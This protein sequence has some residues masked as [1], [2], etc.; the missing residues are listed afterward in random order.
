M[1]PK[2]AT[3]IETTNRIVQ[4]ES[5]VTQQY[6]ELRDGL[7][8]MELKQTG[9]VNQLTV[10]M[11]AINES[12]QRLST[13]IE[14]LGKEV[15]QL[16]KLVPPDPQLLINTPGRLN[17]TA[18]SLL[19][20]NPVTPVAGQSS[21]FLQGNGGQHRLP[22]VEFP[23]FNGEQVRSWLQKAKRFFLLH[24]MDEQQKVLF[25]SLNFTDAAETWF[26]TDSVNFTAMGWNQFSVLI[27]SRFS[28]ELSENVVGEFKKLCQCNTVKEYQQHFEQLRPLVLL[29]NPGLSEKYFID[30]CIAGLKEEIR[31][32]VQMFNPGSVQSVF[33]LAKL[34]EATVDLRNKGRGNKLS[35]FSPFYPN[36][37]TAPVS[38]NPLVSRIVGSVDMNKQGT[39]LHSGRK[40]TPIQI[41]ER[42]AKGL[43]YNCDEAWS[44]N[45][46]CTSKQLFYIAGDSDESP[47]VSDTASVPAPSD[48]SAPVIIPEVAISLQA[49]SGNTSYQTL[50]LKGK[51]KNRELT[52]LIDTGSTHNFLDAN[53]ANA[54]GCICSSIP[55]HQLLVAG[56]SHLTCDKV[57]QNFSWEINGVRFISDVRI[58]PLGGCEFVLGVQWLTTIGPTITLDFAKL[59][60][61]FQYNNANVLLKGVKSDSK[62]SL[63]SMQAVYKYS[64]SNPCVVL[65]LLQSI[66]DLNGPSVVPSDI[67]LLLQPLILDFHDIFA[68]PKGLPPH[69]SLD[70]SITLKPN[71]ESTHTRPYRYPQIQKK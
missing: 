11:A 26:Q 13:R 40:L 38:S 4:L 19:G 3:A 35:T 68:E 9:D 28:E 67:P 31:H 62:L 53:T 5:R 46:K 60:L 22:R 56:G 43:C 25:A 71:C 33:A 59:E 20:S 70:H 48:A 47:D 30:S 24:I 44:I 21:D 45:H 49:L 12:L 54:L 10:T 69:R 1:A 23:K 61:S 16:K 7:E 18:A 63:L 65:V 34:H 51:V 64:T 52:M 66:H 27:Q 15:G 55:S 8:R 14:V 58:L 17:P 57:C 39:V 42:R 29:Q 32:P 2:D 6:S 37:K 41:Q 50:M 36:V